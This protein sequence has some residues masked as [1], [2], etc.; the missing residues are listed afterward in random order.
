MMVGGLHSHGPDGSASGYLETFTFDGYVFKS[1]INGLGEIYWNLQKL[2]FCFLSPAWVGM[3]GRGI[4]PPPK[5]ETIGYTTTR[6]G[7]QWDLE[8]ELCGV[9]NSLNSIHYNL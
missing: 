3:F 6:E 1:L 5:K 8:C 2:F 4:V 7:N 9:Y